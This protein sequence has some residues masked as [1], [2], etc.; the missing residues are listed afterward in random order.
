MPK[1]LPVDATRMSQ[2]AATSTPPGGCDADVAAGGHL[3]T[4]AEAESFD[5]RDDGYRQGAEARAQAVQS[6]DEVPGR[7]RIEPRHLLDV[8]AADPRLPAG[9]REDDRAGR[10]VTADT[11]E[12]IRELGEQGAVEDVEPPGAVHG[13]AVQVALVAPLDIDAQ[14]AVA[15]RCAHSSRISKVLTMD[16]G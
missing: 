12:R 4:S 2:Q 15:V 5:A 3:D 14:R 9:A 11:R 1:R 8:G 16:G 10:I 13:Q 7:L 6:P